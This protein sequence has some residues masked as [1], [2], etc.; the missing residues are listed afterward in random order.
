MSDRLLI[1]CHLVICLVVLM[2]DLEDGYDYVDYDDYCIYFIY[3][4]MLVLCM[5]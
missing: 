1:F 5:L 4:M 3:P 2:N